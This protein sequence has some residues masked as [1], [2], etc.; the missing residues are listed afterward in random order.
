[1]LPRPLH[2]WKSF[3]LGILVLAFLGCGW[4]RSMSHTDGFFWLPKHFIFTAHQSTGQLGFAW[5][6][7]KPASPLSMFQWVHEPISAAGEPWFPSAVVPE[8]YDR[9]FQF[10]IAHWFLMLLFLIAWGAFIYWRVRR[11]KRLAELGPR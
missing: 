2:R 7:S 5:D 11:M 8:V 3:W 9:Q 6:Y 4:L 10:A 1:M